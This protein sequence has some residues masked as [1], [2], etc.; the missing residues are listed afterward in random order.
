[1]IQ[2]DTEEPMALLREALPRAVR[3]H[4]PAHPVTLHLQHCF[5]RLY[6]ECGLLPE[7][8]K[9]TRETL[10]TRR[11]ATPGHEGVGRTL[12]ILGRVLFQENQLQE[13]EMHLR[14]A[15]AFF[16]NSYKNNKP[17]L[18][19]QVEN[20]LGAIMVTRREFQ[21]AE[22]MMLPDAEQLLLPSFEMAPG[23]RRLAIENIVRLYQA[24]EKPGESAKWQAKLDQ[25]ASP[26]P[27]TQPPSSPSPNR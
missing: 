19:V 9:I 18:I 15:R 21:E 5:G 12:L 17:N 24:W 3:V 6:A 20:L 26:I 11:V 7:A 14:E 8:E 1:M 25:V 22:K 10:A 4:G 16:R 23:E 2:G 27:P 13:A